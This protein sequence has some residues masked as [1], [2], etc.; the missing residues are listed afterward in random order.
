MGPSVIISNLEG[1][2]EKKKRVLEKGKEYFHV[3]ADFDRTLTK[4]IVNG[5]ETPSIISE[6]RRGN[7]LS[8]EYSEKANALAEKY[9]SI[10]IDPKIPLKEKK[11]AMQ[12]WWKE[13]FDLLIESGLN[14]KH[15]EQVVDSGKMQF[16]KGALT[17]LDIL[18]KKN[19]PLVIMSSGGLG[20]D[21]I[22]MTLKKQKRLYNNIYI[23]SNSFEWDSNGRAVGVKKPIIHVLNKDEFSL[24][25]LPIYDKLLKRKNVLL[26]GDSLGD[27]GM[28][29]G[30]RYD[31]LIKVGFLNSNIKEN[32]EIYKKSYDVLILNDGTFGFVNNLL[33]GLK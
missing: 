17:L 26:L 24:K 5:I 31:N 23:I 27:L 6:L 19:I 11:R 1:F 15:I 4:A 13:H 28:I 22:S 14:K 3:L 12:E 9:H 8:E 32:L 18:Y 33:R 30:F 16:R 21:S 20:G 25:E 2:E 29:E 10:E 7:Y